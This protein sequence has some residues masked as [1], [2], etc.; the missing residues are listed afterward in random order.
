[1]V[2]S[3][4][5][6][7]CPLTKRSTR[8]DFPTADS[9]KST[10]LN[11]QILLPAFGPLGRVAPPLPAMSHSPVCRLPAIYCKEKPNKQ[12]Q[13]Q[14]KLPKQEK[15]NNTKVILTHVWMCPPACS[16]AEVVFA[17]GRRL[18]G[19]MLAGIDF[20]AAA[21]S[22]EM[23]LPEILGFSLWNSRWLFPKCTWTGVASS[24]PKQPWV[25]HI[26]L[27]QT[28]IHSPHCLCDFMMKRV[29]GG[30]Q[31]CHNTFTNACF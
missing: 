16:L 24:I 27:H 20:K 12:K 17:D 8:L 5:S 4:N 22:V 15:E 1:M 18:S 30:C 10:S 31:S 21:E 28:A 7:N 23:S 29:S 19:E 11:W 13:T 26:C 25:W 9:P 6:W 2:L 3:W 14:K